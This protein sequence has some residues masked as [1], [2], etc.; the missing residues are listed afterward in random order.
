MIDLSEDDKKTLLNIARDAV[1]VHLSGNGSRKKYNLSDAL[2]SKCGA[3]VTLKNKGELRGCI[4]MLQSEKEL[5]GTVA[6]MA[7]SAATNDTRFSSVEISELSDLDIEISVLSPFKIIKNTD[8]IEVGKHGILIQ[9]LPF[10]GLLL[11]Q[12]ATENKWDRNTFLEYTCMKAGLST[13]A[14]KEKDTVIQIFSADVF[15]EK[16]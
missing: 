7:V 13:N 10:Q 12:V 4:G 5:H 2:K 16:E 6:D 11:P 9:K 8:E 1:K 14:W 3:F 15:G